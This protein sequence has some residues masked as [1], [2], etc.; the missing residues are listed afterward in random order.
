VTQSGEIDGRCPLWVK[1][2]HDA[3]KSRCPLY[4]QSGHVRCN[5][6]CPLC[7]KSG[8]IDGLHGP[9]ANVLVFDRNY[10]AFRS[11][12]LQMFTVHFERYF[13]CPC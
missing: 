8:G 4:P 5:Y 7:V 1:T 13:G 9:L 11:L 6:G 2:R 10:V 12:R 3:L